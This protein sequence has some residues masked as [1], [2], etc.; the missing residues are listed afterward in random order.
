MNAHRDDFAEAVRV[1]LDDLNMQAWAQSQA[2]GYR[3]SAVDCRARAHRALRR[4][5]Y[6]DFRHFIREAI[7]H[8]SLHK[9]YARRAR[10]YQ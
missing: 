1:C 3:A 9:S 8:W 6:G 2:A 7:R 5:F 10:A 4:G